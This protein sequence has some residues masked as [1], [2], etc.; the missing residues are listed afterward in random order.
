MRGR[1]TICG[2]KLKIF[3]KLKI[4]NSSYIVEQANTF[5]IKKVKKFNKDLVLMKEE[6]SFA[7]FSV[8][9]TFIII[10]RFVIEMT[11]LKKLSHCILERNFFLNNFSSK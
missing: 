6:N 4:S 5:E 9:S 8:T 7:N 1:C 3:Y 10:F 2:L 11:S